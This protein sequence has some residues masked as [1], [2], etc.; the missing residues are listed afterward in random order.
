MSDYQ[1][2]KLLFTL[3][4]QHRIVETVSD[5]AEL[6]A[7]ELSPEEKEALKRGDVRRLYEL[8]AN[9]YLLRRVFR[10]RFTV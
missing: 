10:P 7:Y 6:A 1:V 4:G 5:E 9:P 3:A 2:N 8:G